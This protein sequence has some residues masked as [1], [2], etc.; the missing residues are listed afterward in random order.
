[1]TELTRKLA[2]KFFEARGREHG[3]EFE[4]WSRAEQEIKRR[5]GL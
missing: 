4:D 1:V 5:F 2:Y 3:H